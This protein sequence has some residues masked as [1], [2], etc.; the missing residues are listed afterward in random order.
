MIK[1]F[2]ISATIIS[3][4]LICGCQQL[5]PSDNPPPENPSVTQPEN[6][7]VEN[8]PQIEKPIVEK[9]ETTP[10][11]NPVEENTNE[12][13]PKIVSPATQAQKI[14]VKVYYPDDAGINLVAVKRNIEIKSEAEKYFAV[15]KL[16]MTPPTEKDLTIIFPNNAKINDVKF[17]NGTVIVDF[18]KNITKSF[19]GGST[20]EELLVNSVVKTLT[21]FKEVKQIRFL[22]DGE[23]IE[24][25]SG[26]M[27]LSE[28]I[29]R[30]DL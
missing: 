18:D 6:K 10:P 24:T 13:T 28:P 27:D 4:M 5:P 11:P 19:A 9:P 20:G 12:E 14:S 8:P 2:F 15:V 29:K 25:L 23:E 3:T 17:D 7:P 21:E 16:L 30:T 22:V 26:H 1:K